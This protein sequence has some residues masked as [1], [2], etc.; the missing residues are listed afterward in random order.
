M[1]VSVLLITIYAFLTPLLCTIMLWKDRKKG[2]VN[3]YALLFYIDV[4]IVFFAI[5]LFNFPNIE[6]NLITSIVYSFAFP[7]APIIYFFFLYFFTTGNNKIPRLYYLLFLLPLAQ[8]LFVAYAF[9]IHSPI[10]LLKDYFIEI[11]FTKSPNFPESLNLAYTAF[12]FTFIL[13]I[14]CLAGLIISSIFYISKITQS[15]MHQSFSLRKRALSRSLI[16]ITSIVILSIGTIIE[17]LSA[18]RLHNHMSLAITELFYGTGWLLNGYF[19]YKELRYKNGAI[20]LP[21]SYNNNTTFLIDQLNTYFEHNKPFL[22]PNLRL[23]DIALALGTNRTYLSDALNN[24]LNTN[25]NRFVNEYRIK[26]AQRLLK[27]GN[28]TTGLQAIAEQSGFNSYS[29]FRRALKEITDTTPNDFVKTFA[30]KTME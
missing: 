19:V 7:A 11:I 21:V 9:Y 30:E 13:M 12:N 1:P 26:E 15:L 23:N 8:S 3:L 5:F 28:K 22:N 4:T 24:E 10:S 18:G 20:P 2:L 25:F 29:T 27:Q 17:I 6:I 16:V 14:V